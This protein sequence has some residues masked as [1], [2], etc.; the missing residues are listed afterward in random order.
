M[1][2]AM[3]AAATQ[4]HL[5][6]VKFIFQHTKTVEWSRQQFF[7]AGPFRC[8][9]LD[10]VKFLCENGLNFRVGD[11]YYL[12]CASKAGHTDVVDYLVGLGANAEIKQKI[13]KLTSLH[14]ELM[15]QFVKIHLKLI[16][17][18]ILNNYLI[19]ETLQMYFFKLADA[20][21]MKHPIFYRQKLYLKIRLNITIY[22]FMKDQHQ[23]YFGQK[24]KF[25]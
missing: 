14:N 4:G 24:I 17:L 2:S 7:M 16:N 21:I 9:H 23:S 25:E 1:M 6:I 5:P 13:I 10:V 12:K 22:T 11:D 18:L 8:G 15:H 20:I 19:Y 3:Y